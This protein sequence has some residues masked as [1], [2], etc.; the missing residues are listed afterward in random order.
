[1]RF[2]SKCVCVCVWYVCVC[3]K[4][5]LNKNKIMLSEA[6]KMSEWWFFIDAI[7]LNVVRV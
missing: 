5:I 7:F 2:R 1:M 6:A 3:Y 4:L